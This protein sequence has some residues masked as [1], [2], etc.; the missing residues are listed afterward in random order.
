[1]FHVPLPL[2]RTDERRNSMLARLRQAI[3]FH[4]EELAFPQP[5]EGFVALC[6]SAMT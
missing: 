6:V 4:Q 2:P 3:R 1:M 5:Q